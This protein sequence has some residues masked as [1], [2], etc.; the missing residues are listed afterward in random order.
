M[1]AGDKIDYENSPF[2]GSGKSKIGVVLSHIMS[3][4]TNIYSIKIKN[5]IY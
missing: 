3:L 2:S 1:I 5:Y 4:T